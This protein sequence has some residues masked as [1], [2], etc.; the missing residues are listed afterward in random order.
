[1]R[2]SVRW[3]GE[4]VQTC[5]SRPSLR[6]ST[7]E[8]FQK[9]DSHRE[10]WHENMSE[11]NLTRREEEEKYYRYKRLVNAQMSDGIEPL[12][13]LRSRFLGTQTD[14]QGW[15]GGGGGEEEEIPKT[16]SGTHINVSMD[17]FPKDGKAPEN[18]FP[19]R[20]LEWKRKQSVR[21]VSVKREWEKRESVLTI[22]WGW[23]VWWQCQL[24]FRQTV[25]CCSN[26]CVNNR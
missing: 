6:T 3:E 19:L 13:W 12:K 17:A 5:K 11:N 23:W 18:R 4:D 15:G 10:T 21:C 20:I 7:W 14:R 1:M 25:G 24:G 9:E 2:A 26:F 8:V 16:S 22:F